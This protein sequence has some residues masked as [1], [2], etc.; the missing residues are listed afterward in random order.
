MFVRDNTYNNIYYI[1]L[2]FLYWLW[3]PPSKFLPHI[4]LKFLRS[5]LVITYF[6]L[7]WLLVLCISH[8]QFCS[9]Y[10]AFVCQVVL[11]AIYPCFNRWLTYSFCHRCPAA[12]ESNPD[13][14]IL[15]PVKVLRPTRSG[16]QF[17]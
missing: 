12:I 15:R 2:Q 6:S 3:I 14:P 10:L 9:M 17:I 1:C 16:T 7:H 13:E 11:L 4:F 5:K 8:I